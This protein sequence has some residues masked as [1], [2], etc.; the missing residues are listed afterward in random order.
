M[1][2]DSLCKYTSSVWMSRYYFFAFHRRDRGII[3]EN[4]GDKCYCITRKGGA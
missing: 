3:L 4:Y 2:W 1:I